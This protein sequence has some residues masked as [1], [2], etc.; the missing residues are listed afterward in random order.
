MTDRVLITPVAIL[1]A[2]EKILKAQVAIQVTPLQV[3]N[4]E[5]TV[6]TQALI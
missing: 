6:A 3:V 1:K 5:I 4:K 2:P